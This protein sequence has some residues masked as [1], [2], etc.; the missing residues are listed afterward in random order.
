MSPP[1]SVPVARGAWGERLLE[2]HFG[3]LGH[4]PNNGFKTTEGPRKLDRI[5][6]DVGYEAKAGKNVKLLTRQTN[7]NYIRYPC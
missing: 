4:K 5:V 2:T 7:T 1:P 3:G 6:G